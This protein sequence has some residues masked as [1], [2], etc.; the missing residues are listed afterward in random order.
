MR[1]KYVKRQ[2]REIKRQVEVER[3]GAME[4]VGV[5]I[6]NA[7]GNNDILSINILRSYNKTK[8][9]LLWKIVLNIK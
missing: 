9:F 7:T 8:L 6:T 2:K 4:Q 1:R 5:E 3:K